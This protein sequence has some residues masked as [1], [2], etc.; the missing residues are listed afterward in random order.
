[1]LAVLFHEFDNLLNVG[2]MKLPF[3]LLIFLIKLVSLAGGEMVFDRS[4]FLL[5]AEANIQLHIVELDL[6]FCGKVGLVF[7][8][9]QSD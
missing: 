5:L 4:E 9:T 1:V 7:I 8:D 2:Q 6:I 3:I